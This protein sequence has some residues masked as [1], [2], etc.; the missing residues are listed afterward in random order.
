MD[1]LRG[2]ALI[3]QRFGKLGSGKDSILVGDAD[4]DIET[5]LARLDLVL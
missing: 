2:R 4:Y 5:A 3:E 1:D